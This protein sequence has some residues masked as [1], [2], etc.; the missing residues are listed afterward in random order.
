MQDDKQQCTI[1]HSETIGSIAPKL[2]RVM[3]AIGPVKKSGRNSY[4]NYDYSTDADVFEAVR[5]PLAAAGVALFSGYSVINREE[6]KTSKGGVARVATVLLEVLLFDESGEWLKSTVVG[7]GEDRG[8]K[9]IPKAVTSAAKYWAKPTFLLATGEDVEQDSRKPEP[10][11]Q[12]R[13]PAKPRQ[14]TKRQPPPSHVS[15]ALKPRQKNDGSKVEQDIKPGPTP[16]TKGRR[17]LKEAAE[18]GA[19]LLLEHKVYEEHIEALTAIRSE[20]LALAGGD[21]KAITMGHVQD[22]TTAIMERALA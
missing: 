10:R 16:M 8:D 7:E 5:G 6:R 17:Q 18:A 9:A 1:T 3:G 20:S 13:Q 11:Q 12:T 4:D 14:A 19:A 22:A 21:G 15:N 2:A